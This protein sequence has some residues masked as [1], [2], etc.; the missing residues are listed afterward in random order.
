M[1]RIWRSHRHGRGSIPRLGVH[2][3]SHSLV[4]LFL[5]ILCFF[6]FH[7]IV[8]VR[9]TFSLFMFYFRQLYRTQIFTHACKLSND[10]EC[11]GAT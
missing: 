5:F 10:S 1:V 6:F 9:L 7:T 3:F 11:L 4:Y 8:L 2:I